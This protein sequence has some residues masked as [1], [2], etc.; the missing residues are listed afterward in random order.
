MDT[1]LRN[2]HSAALFMSNR[3]A[4]RLHKIVKNIPED[5]KNIAILSEDNEVLFMFE[6]NSPSLKFGED[7]IISYKFED[8]SGGVILA[9]SSI[10]FLCELWRMHKAVYWNTED[11][12]MENCSEIRYLN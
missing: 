3:I 10:M 7:D 9:F 5:T 8:L 11:T 6:G 4:E 1:T 12:T 2:F